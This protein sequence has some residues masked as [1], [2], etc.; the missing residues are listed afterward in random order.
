MA[1]KP[2][3]KNVE[4]RR[5]TQ[6][7]LEF[8]E[9]Y[10]GAW[11]M[12]LARS[13]SYPFC[14]THLWLVDTHGGPGAHEAGLDPDGVIE[15]T[16]V[17]AVLAARATQR[18]FPDMTVHVRATE[19]DGPTAARLEAAV[20]PF[21]GD[22]PRGVDVLVRKRDWVGEVPAILA[23]ID[24]EDHPHG[25]RPTGDRAHDHRSLWF[26]DPNGIESIDHETIERL[27]RGY[28]VIVNL[29][30]MATMRH[31]GK[32]RAGDR[33]SLGLLERAFGGNAWDGPSGLRPLADAF[34]GTFRG[35]SYRSA[36]LMSSTGSQDRAMVHL[37]R[38]RRAVEAFDKSFGEALRAGTVLAGKA[39]TSVQRDNAAVRLFEL[40]RGLT[41][42]TRQMA[43]GAP[44]YTLDQLRT[45]CRTAETNR[46]GQFDEA[47]STMTWYEERQPPLSLFG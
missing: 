5:Q 44:R 11:C 23:E 8:M 37:T 24:M 4:Q 26:I 25:G 38:S 27:P 32:A 33:S 1:E 21:R 22:P 34:A 45:I 20:A 19:K 35:W 29:D 16:P 31:V 14:P 12:I 30:L 36:S 10:W 13:R 39:T 7:K 18:A 3:D 47:T 15:G 2:A 43:A 9:R 28:E 6:H 41:L 42:T 17:L 40:F 46:Y